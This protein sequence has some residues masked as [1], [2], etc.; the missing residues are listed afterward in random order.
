[1]RRYRLFP[2]TGSAVA[3]ALLIWAFLIH[4]GGAVVEAK[5]IL[6]SF[7]TSLHNG[8]RVTIENIVADHADVNLKAVVMFDRPLTLAQVLDSDSAT[9]PVN[10]VYVDCNV[11][12][13]E[14]GD[15]DVAGLALA[16]KVAITPNEQWVYTRFDEIPPQLIAQAPPL[17]LFAGTLRAGLLIDLTGLDLSKYLHD[18]DLVETKRD[19][20]S[21]WTLD[22]SSNSDDQDADA[23]DGHSAT[24]G[25][26]VGDGQASV[27]SSA[28]VDGQLLERLIDDVL[29]GRAGR[30]Q[31]DQIAGMIEESSQ[32]V[33]VTE[34]EPGLYVLT[35]RDFQIPDDDV[36]LPLR[37]AVLQ[38]AYRQGDGVQ[39]ARFDGVGQRH[40]SIRLE[41]I[42]QIDQIDQLSKDH[43]TKDGVTRVLE[44]NKLA[45]MIESLISQPGLLDSKGEDR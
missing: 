26:H 16:A 24:V 30:E 13:D 25:V 39:W 44:A 19:G 7:R 18:D 37:D 9:P 11:R 34:T 2:V 8:L 1:M 31:L 28:N 23:D 20:K 27:E 42:D 14:R 6:E 12:I 43:F 17:A 41:F 38:I 29:H 10:S 5:A 21:G 45:P 15:E 36:D 3:A 22:L 35:A 40:G 33:K 4:P 32:N